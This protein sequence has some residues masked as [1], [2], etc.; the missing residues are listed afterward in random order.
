MTRDIVCSLEKIYVI[1]YIH[2]AA[3]EVLYNK[4]IIHHIDVVT[5]PP[6]TLIMYFLSSNIS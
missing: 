3:N 4:N 2:V 5:K 1:P 6:R